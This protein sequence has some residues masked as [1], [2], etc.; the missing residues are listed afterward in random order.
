M[1]ARRLMPSVPRR[2]AGLTY[3][4][5]SQGTALRYDAFGPSARVRFSS[6]AVAK[7]SGYQFG[8]KARSNFS[9]ELQRN[10]AVNNQF[11][12]RDVFR[13]VRSKI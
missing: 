9:T 7:K 6:S 10:S 13:L 3:G 5:Q 12:A 8:P 2:F 4:S 1:N 11:E